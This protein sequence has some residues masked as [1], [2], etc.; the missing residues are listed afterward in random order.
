MRLNVHLLLFPLDLHYRVLR[1]LVR[2]VLLVRIQLVQWHHRV[3]EL[4]LT[5]R[6]LLL[7]IGRRMLRLGFL[8]DFPLASN[9]VFEQ[10]PRVLD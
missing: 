3:A 10:V 6:R 5:L 8:G 9:Y 7:F 1:C 4:A 2:A